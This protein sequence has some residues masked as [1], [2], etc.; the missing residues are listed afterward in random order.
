MHILQRDLLLQYPFRLTRILLPVMLLHVKQQG[1]LPGICI[2]N[3]GHDRLHCANNGCSSSSIQV[4]GAATI[5]DAFE[6]LEL[7]R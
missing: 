3:S 1:H 2:Q 4:Q 7:V 6:G 5:E